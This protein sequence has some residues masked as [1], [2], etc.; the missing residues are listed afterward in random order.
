MARIGVVGGGLSGITHALANAGEDVTLF[1][2][3]KQLGG[4]LIPW[5]ENG[6]YLDKGCHVFD[7]TDQAE[8]N[9]YDDVLGKDYLDLDMTYASVTEEGVREGMAMPSF[10]G[11]KDLDYL[12]CD[13]LR[14][15][16]ELSKQKALE[17]VHDWLIQRYGQKLCA[18]LAPMVKKFSRKPPSEMDVSSVKSLCDFERIELDGAEIT[19]YLKRINEQLDAALALPSTSSPYHFYPNSDNGYRGRNIYPAKKGL[20]GF[21]EKLDA[22]LKEKKV[23]VLYDQKL[24]GLKVQND[25]TIVLI[26]ESSSEVHLDRLIWCA[27]ESHLQNLLLK[28]N[29]LQ[30][31][32][33][34]TPLICYF[35]IIP[36]REEEQNPLTFYHDYRSE[37]KI[38]RAATQ[39]IYGKQV[40]RN[41]ETYVCAEVPV[42]DSASAIWGN[43]EKYTDDIWMEMLEVGV[44]SGKFNSVLVKKASQSIKIFRTGYS[45]K[46]AEFKSRVSSISGRIELPKTDWDSHRGIM[47]S[48]KYER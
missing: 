19:K 17:T 44:V 1:E 9:L 46:L 27:P 11:R 48:A 31:W 24:T 36:Y 16:E 32:A 14:S 45:Q 2:Y 34:P 18:L 37:S 41:G 26:D 40:N 43:P 28:T 13:F 35:F 29:D 10:Q 5:Y 22:Y 42:S 12:T 7:R 33:I 21:V 23:K 8:I 15:R 38:Y 30:N 4:L 25:G 39:G 20:Q 47:E 3:S 6:L